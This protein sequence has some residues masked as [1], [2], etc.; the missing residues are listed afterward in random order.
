M[1][2]DTL[3][4]IRGALLHRLRDWLALPEGL[5]SGFARAV[6]PVVDA[7]RFADVPTVRR[8]LVSVNGNGYFDI[9]DVVGF[10]F[11]VLHLYC[12]LNSGTFTIGFF[13]LL[14][15]AGN[16]VTL[17]STS[18][19]TLRRSDLCPLRVP[20]GW[21]LQVTISGFSVAGDVGVDGVFYVPLGSVQ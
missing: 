9:T 7:T 3:Y 6:V 14:D 8:R 16:I 10:E 11:E 2:F 15:S 20:A 1:T 17:S 19:G 5:M 21:K 18:V 12:Y 4:R 13:R